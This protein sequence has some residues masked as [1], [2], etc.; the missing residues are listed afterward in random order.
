M[1]RVVTTSTAIVLSV[2]GDRQAVYDAPVG[3]LPRTHAV[4]TPLPDRT[5]RR[6]LPPA[7]G[8]TCSPHAVRLYSQYTA[9]MSPPDVH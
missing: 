4:E 3:R 9:S 5:L 1:N 6:T 8:R 7:T 2:P